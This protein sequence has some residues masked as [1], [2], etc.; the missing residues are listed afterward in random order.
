MRADVRKVCRAAGFGER[1]GERQRLVEDAGAA[2][3]DAPDCRS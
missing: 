3:R 2:I 1:S